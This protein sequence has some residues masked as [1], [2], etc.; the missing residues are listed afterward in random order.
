VGGVARH[1]RIYARS[2]PLGGRLA[3]GG[4][5]LSAAQAGGGPAST[6]EPAVPEPAATEPAIDFDQGG[7]VEVSAIAPSGA[8]V[9]LNFDGRQAAQGRA[10]ASGRYDASLPAA[11]SQTRILPGAH[12]VQVFGDGFSDSVTF[13]VSAAPPLA[14]GPLRSQFTSAGLRVDWMTPGGG[15]Q[16]TVLAP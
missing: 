10:E 12:Q 2:L 11:G 8:T 15:V 7:G 3:P 1:G 14:Q 5:A 13:Q 4:A 6:G 16:S 9:I